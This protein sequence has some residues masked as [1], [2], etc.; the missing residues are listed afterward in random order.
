MRTVSRRWGKVVR[1]LAEAGRDVSP[2]RARAPV[3]VER[4]KKGAGRGKN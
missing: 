4:I 1:V 2:A 3:T